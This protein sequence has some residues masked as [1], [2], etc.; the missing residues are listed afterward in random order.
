MNNKI[1]LKSYFKNLWELYGV[2]FRIGAVT[3]GGGLAML[4]IMERELVDKRSWT[5][6][7]ELMDFY[8]ISQ[9][10][11]G[12]VA[13]NVA[14]FLGYYRGGIIGGIVATMGVVTPSVIIITIIALFLQNFMDIIWVQKAMAG[15]NVAVAAMLSKAVLTFAKRSI[16]KVLGFLIF[17]TA[18]VC[19]HFF[20]INTVFIIFG[21]ALIGIIYFVIST[22]HNLKKT[23]N[24]DNI[25]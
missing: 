17:I 12:V 15:I 22:K 5:N 24:K 20:K 3:F 4:P 21:S 25:K 23:K 13:V 16:K 14:T 1:S 9:S 7:E 8:A 19:M 18:F 2:F 6:R 10:T 11:P